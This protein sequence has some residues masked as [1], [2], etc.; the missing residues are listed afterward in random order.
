MK[1]F[2]FTQAQIDN[3]KSDYVCFDCGVQFL[4]EEQKK[5]DGRVATFSVSECCL[6]GEEKGTTNIRT[7][8]YLR[9]PKQYLQNGKE[10]EKKETKK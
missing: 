10:T 1:K 5:N 2:N 3:R 4:T 6:C 9:I 7:Y 8:N